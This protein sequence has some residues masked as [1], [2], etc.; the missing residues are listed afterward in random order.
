MLSDDERRARSERLRGFE[1]MERLKVVVATLVALAVVG[2]LLWRV[3]TASDP[4]PRGDALIVGRCRADYQ[5]AGSAAES[6]VVDAR[7]PIFDP[8]WD[9]PRN[10]SCGELRRTGQLSH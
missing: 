6:L 5:R 3:V 9:V 1:R 7:R 2:V 8:E 4:L 10:I